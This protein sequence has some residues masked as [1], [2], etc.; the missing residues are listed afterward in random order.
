[1]HDR[2]KAAAAGAKKRALEAIHGKASDYLT[3]SELMALTNLGK[4]ELDAMRKE[5]RLPIEPI[6][7]PPGGPLLWNK[8]EVLSFIRRLEISRGAPIGPALLSVEQ[9]FE[10]LGAAL[11]REV[12]AAI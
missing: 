10:A 7:G 4:G 3:T 12:R 1:M 9:A 8:S 6:Q 5:G 11:L 2:A